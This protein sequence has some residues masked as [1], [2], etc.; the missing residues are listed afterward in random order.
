MLEIM[1]RA[2]LVSNVYVYSSPLADQT[3][4]LKQVKETAGGNLTGQQKEDIVR[5]KKDLMKEFDA[6]GVVKYV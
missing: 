6:A 2:R 4:F 1:A 3:D 5:I